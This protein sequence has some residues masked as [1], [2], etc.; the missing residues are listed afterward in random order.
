ML[1]PMLQYLENV[2]QVHQWKGLCGNHRKLNAHLP[3]EHGNKSSGVITLVDIPKIDEMLTHLHESKFFTSLDMGS[4]YY[5]IKLSQETRHIST[6]T[7]IFS[8]YKFLRLPFGLTQGPAYFTALIQK[9][10]GY[11]NDLCFFHMDDVF[12]HDANERD[13]LEHLKMIF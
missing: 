1:H 4:G 10:F 12:V 8:K 2:C 7:T 6:F 13:H 11:I 9:V 5:H 3:T